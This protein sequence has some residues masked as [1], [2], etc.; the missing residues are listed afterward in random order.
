M[1]Q[2]ISSAFRAQTSITV[3][4]FA[5]VNLTDIAQ[6]ASAWTPGATTIDT[7]SIQPPLGEI[8]SIVAHAIT[9]DAFMLTGTPTYGKLGR[10]LGGIVRMAPTIANPANANSPWTNP[11]LPLPD[12][13]L[14]LTTLWDG[15]SDPV[16]RNINSGDA[17]HLTGQL[18]LP[19]PI[20]I[21]PGDTLQMGLWI[22]PSLAAGVQLA[23]ADATYAIF[24]DDNRSPTAPG[25]IWGT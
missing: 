17:T 3:S 7:I 18:S 16:V 9:L 4:P 15:T 2:T 1:I 10:I 20:T 12:N 5:P 23:V 25:N 21:P 19:V 11:A 24:Y 22:T 14:G 13:T 6:A 8:W